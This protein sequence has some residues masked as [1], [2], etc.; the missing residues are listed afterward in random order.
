[1]LELR[2]EEYREEL[3]EKWDDFVLTKSTNGTFLQTRN[4]LNEHGNR[5]TDRS[6]LICKG[7]N[8]IVA[9]VPACET[10]DGN[11]K[12]YNSHG[13]STFGGVVIGNE[14]YDI[15]HVEAMIGVLEDYVKDNGYDEVRLCCTSDIFARRDTE[16]LKYFLYQKGYREYD[17]LSCYIDFNDYKED[18]ASNFSAARRR[19]CKYAHRYAME[20]KKLET[21]TELE[22]FYQILCDNLRKYD[23]K[24]VHSL[25]ELVEF[26]EK[27]LADVVE[28]YGVYME[29]R[30]IAGSMVFKF[31][32][33]VFHTQ[34]LAADQSCLNLYPMN[35]L[36][37]G[38]ITT[39]RD[40]GFQYFSFGISTEDKGRILNKSLAQFKEGFGA[41]F[42]INRTYIKKVER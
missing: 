36:D 32:M 17:E 25:E 22:E 31:E 39:A 18:V 15:E 6:L 8:T 5:F 30:I 13:G 1:M 29:K 28:F 34:Y 3:Q 38:L 24:P 26:K 16:L 21:R 35:F 37:E 12:I 20:L 2:I 4:F 23:T 19:G 42:G 11:K 9:V 40:E 10:F 41:K 14:F 33:R 27:R 7:T